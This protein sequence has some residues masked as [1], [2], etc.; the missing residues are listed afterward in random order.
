MAEIDY[1]TRVSDKLA[2]IGMSRWDALLAQQPSSSP[3]MS[4]A[5]LDALQSSGSA[6]EDTGWT[7]QYLSLWHGDELVAACPLYL[8]QHSYGEYVFDWSWAQAHEQHGIRYYPKGLVA[9]PF[10]P[11]PGPRLLA[12]DDAA[13]A[14]LVRALVAQVQA[15][16]LSSLHLLFLAPQD[17]Q[18]CEQA[19]LMLRHTVQFHW[20][21]A[22]PDG[23]PLR[24]MDHFLATLQQE[25][26][27]KIRQ[28]RRKVLEAGVSFRHAEGAQIS[29]ADWAFFE[30][31]YRQ[32]YY[33]H[34]NAP[35]L[36]P[37]FFERMQR[38]MASHW[39]LFIAE[40]EGRPIASS[41][42][43]IDRAQGVA[44]GRYWG[45]LERVDCLHFEACYY[46]PLAWCLAQGF[47]RFEGGAQGEHKMA[48]ALLPVRTTSAHWLAHPTFADA[49]DRFLDRE[50]QGIEQYLDHLQ[51]RSPLRREAP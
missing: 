38:D 34:G 51:A 44:Y 39:L 22:G 32:T 18:A 12:R 42:I 3:F 19:G 10:T 16:R 24:D 2:D 33:E 27:K 36:Q 17:L 14:A 46:Q 41:L 9:V 13:R 23:Q 20:Q 45:A 4:A 8:K 40:R 29:A 7:P 15:W 43:G 31:C 47:R 35:Y 25:K 48:R 21:N 37:G 28:E 26:R 50:G 6:V 30:R 49:V 5:Y 11:V 1:V